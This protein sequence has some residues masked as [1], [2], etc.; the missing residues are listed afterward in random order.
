MAHAR[1]SFCSCDR[2]I[3]GSFRIDDQGG[4]FTYTK[5]EP[6]VDISGADL[7]PSTPT[8]SWAFVNSKPFSIDLT[9]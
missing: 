7:H 2:T 1:A 6:N 9:P 4:L 5:I 8:A 3:D